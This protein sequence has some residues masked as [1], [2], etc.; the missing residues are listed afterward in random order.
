MKSCPLCGELL[1]DSVN[2]CFNCGY[3]YVN[4]DAFKERIQKKEELEAELERQKK[5][6]KEKLEKQRQ[7]RIR[8]FI[9]VSAHILDGY[10]ITE[11]IGM[12]NGEAALGTGAFSEL[13]SSISDLFGTNS[14]G[15]QAK[16]SN[17][18]NIAIHNMIS[19]ALSNGADG[20]IAVDIDLNVLA[21]NMILVSANGTAVKFEKLNI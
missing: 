6:E 17:A 21:N 16:L 4:P 19:N 11:Y 9:T 7:E 8:N 3:D 1:G 10:R 15:F 13:D 5:E 2:K 20:I 14:T 12:V 18:K